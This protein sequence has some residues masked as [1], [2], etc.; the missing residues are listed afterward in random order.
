MATVIPSNIYLVKGNIVVD[1]LSVCAL[2]TCMT[3]NMALLVKWS[4]RIIFEVSWHVVVLSRY[5]NR[6][7]MIGETI[8]F[9]SLPVDVVIILQCRR[10][11]GGDDKL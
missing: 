6:N 2:G 9:C 5:G 3:I 4:W 1:L 10:Y 11:C 7:R 8:I